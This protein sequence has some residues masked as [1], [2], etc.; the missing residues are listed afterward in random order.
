MNPIT[1]ICISRN[2]AFYSSVKHIF[3]ILSDGSTS[4]MQVHARFCTNL[5]IIEL[6]CTQ[7]KK[8]VEK[9]PMQDTCQTCKSLVQVNLYKFHEYMSPLGI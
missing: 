7:C 9:K 5:C 8:C 3:I 4:L 2:M 1:Q 6:D